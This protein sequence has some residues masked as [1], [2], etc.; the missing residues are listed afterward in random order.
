MFE[1]HPRSPEAH[2]Q[3][4]ITDSLTCTVVICRFT[5]VYSHTCLSQHPEHVWA[6][7][8][9]HCLCLWSPLI[10]SSNRTEE[11]KDRRVKPV[12]DE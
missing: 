7:G 8:H 10:G 11:H 1:S 6:D 5:L 12:I 9:M 2:N 3:S 4:V